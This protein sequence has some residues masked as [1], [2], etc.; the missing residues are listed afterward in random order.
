MDSFI[1]LEKEKQISHQL[2]A[3]Q[4][5]LNAFHKL[6]YEN[7]IRI[8]SSLGNIAITRELAK[9]FPKIYDED[10]K[11]KEAMYDRLIKHIEANNHDE[12]IKQLKREIQIIET[13]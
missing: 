12:E 9:V 5:E 11:E 13:L 1:Q 10:L 4:M 6:N 7:D 2:R 8:G 3:K